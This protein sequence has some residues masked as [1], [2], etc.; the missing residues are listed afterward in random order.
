ML[1]RDMQK[2]ISCLKTGR[3]RSPMQATGGFFNQHLNLDFSEPFSNESNVFGQRQS[4][5]PMKNRGGT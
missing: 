4:S 5:L 1:Q 2:R 3:N